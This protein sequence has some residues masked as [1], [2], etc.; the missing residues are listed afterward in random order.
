[1]LIRHDTL[2]PWALT[3]WLWKFV[4]DLMSRCQSVV[5]LIE[6]KQFPAVIFCP[7]YVTLWPWPLT[8][9]PWTF[10][11]EILVL[12]ASCVQTLYKI[13]A[14]SNNPRQNCWFRTFS[15]SN[16]RGRGTFSRRFSGV[17][18]PNF[19]KLGKNVGRSSSRNRFVSEFRHLAAFSNADGS[20]AKMRLKFSL[21]TAPPH[22]N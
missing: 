7:Y 22:E 13:W 4:V 6:I 15:P 11:F 1:M 5:N 9:W 10:Y 20:K 12:R 2:W 8:S 18:G 19:N 21:L 17:R 14:K 3:R 16:F